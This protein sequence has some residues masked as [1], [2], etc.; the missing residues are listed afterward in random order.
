VKGADPRIQMPI[1]AAWYAE[2]LRSFILDGAPI[3]SV[4]YLFASDDSPNWSENHTKGWGFGMIKLTEPYAEWFPYW[5]NYIFG[6]NLHVGDNIWNA[7]TSNFTAVSALAWENST[8]YNIIL[9]GKTDHTVTLNIQIANAKINNGTIIHIHL[10]DGKK[11]GIQI[12]T[13]NYLPQFK[14]RLYGYSV[15]LLAIHKSS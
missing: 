13:G 9:I 3:Y 6:R 10:I 12:T 15:V 5:T 8:Y 14:I 4:Y 1:G 2:V 11:E 7:L